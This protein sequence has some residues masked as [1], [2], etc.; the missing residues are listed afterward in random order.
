MA[1]FVA[2]SL[3]RILVCFF[4]CSFKR[5]EFF[6]KPLAVLSHLRPQSAYIM[7]NYGRAGSQGGRQPAAAKPPSY[8]GVNVRM[9]SRMQRNCYILL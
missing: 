3:Y 8:D 5:H 7:G 2:G 6:T 4:S 9:S 1:N